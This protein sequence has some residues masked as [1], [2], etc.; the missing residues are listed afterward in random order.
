[1]SLIVS[2]K[3]RPYVLL[4]TMNRPEKRNALSV[5][6]LKEMAGILTAASED[7]SVRCVVL[8]GDAKA[9]SAG[10]DIAD[11]HA[12]G[13]GS[14]LGH[15]RLAAWAVVENFAKP[16]IAAVNGFALGGGNELVLLCDFAIAGEG[17]LFGLPEINLGIFPGDGATQR[18]P[19]II[20]RAN[21]LRMIL[22]G[23]RISASRAYDMGLVTEVVND[24]QT[25][26]RA[27]DVAAAIA[28]K[29]PI[30]VNLAKK[31]IV[32]GAEM[33]LAEGLAM[34]RHNLA[35]AFDT[36]DQKEGMAAF[37]EKRQPVFRGR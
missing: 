11:Q 23:E 25:I 29:S 35:V 20:G 10:A 15:D 19:R 26:E 27:L 7:D 24:S 16:K 21:T 2:T 9:F 4:I 18:L 22:T 32:E 14:A 30:A 34:E 17:A 5:A 33:S 8:T 3:P 12:R 36:E 13:T 31:T 6:L 28:S 1:M 37:V